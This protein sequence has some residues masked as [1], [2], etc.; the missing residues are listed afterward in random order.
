V[1]S[2]PKPYARAAASRVLGG[3]A[4]VV[5]E[6]RRHGDHCLLHL[7]PEVVL[8]DGL[9]LLEHQRGDLGKAEDVLAD[10]DADGVVV[11]LDDLVR[12]HR[13]RL[14]HLVRE[15][16]AADE[17]LGRVDRVLRVGDDVALGAVADQHRSVF[18]E[19][20][21]RGVRA[22]APLVGNDRGLVAFEDGHAAVAGAEVDA[23]RDLARVGHG[24]WFSVQG[25]KG[26][27]DSRRVL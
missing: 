4:L 9:H 26:V 21:D 19:A 25:Q 24:A 22:L 7:V 6:V 13:L 20:D 10:L 23:D 5:V 16:E 15:V 8:D 11:A 14:L 18:Q 2:L 3:L 27:R 1:I 12:H 17:A